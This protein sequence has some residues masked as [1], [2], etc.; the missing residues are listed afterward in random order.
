MRRKFSNREKFLGLILLCLILVFTIQ[1]IDKNN[2]DEEQSSLEVKEKIKMDKINFYN[3]KKDII[4]QI[5]N[6]INNIVTINYINKD[7]YIDEYNNQSTDIEL[8]I[9]GSIDD[10]LKIEG[11]LKNIG[12]ENS[13]NKIEIVKSTKNIKE[14]DTDKINNYV[15]CIM[16]IKVV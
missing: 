6:E 8:H 1:F 15:D 12:L 7:L 11:S 10:I 3:N 4:L 14:E 5:E 2:G 13:I 16:K 9:S